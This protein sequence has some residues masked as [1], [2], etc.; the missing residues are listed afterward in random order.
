MANDGSDD[1]DDQARYDIYRIV[2]DKATKG[3]L[4][5]V[6]WDVIATQEV[7]STPWEEFPS[8]GQLRLYVGPREAGC[9][10]ALDWAQPI[11]A[12]RRGKNG[13]DGE[14]GAIRVDGVLITH[15]PAVNVHLRLVPFGP[16]P[17]LKF[18]PGQA[19]DGWPNGIGL[20][21]AWQIVERDHSGHIPRIAIL[22]DSFDD[23]KSLSL[24]PDIE[25]EPIGLPS[26][27]F[28][29]GG[30][31]DDHGIAMTEAVAYVARYAKIG[32][33]S[34][35][36]PD[37][38]YAFPSDVA[39]AVA[40][41]V[42]SWKADIVLLA[43]ANY[44][45]GMP[46][47]LRA[48]LSEAAGAAGRRGRGAIIVAPCGG[49][50]DQIWDRD[51]RMVVAADDFYH[52]PGV[53]SVG[54]VDDDGRWYRDLGVAVNGI[55]P[56]M[57]LCAPGNLVLYGKIGAD[58]ASDASAIIAGVSALVLRRNPALTLAELRQVFRVTATSPATIETPG[59]D[60]AESQAFN[61]RDR[62]QHN[63]KIGF[64]RVAAQA[65]VLAASDPFCYALLA[66]RAFPDVDLDNLTETKPSPGSMLDVALA[67]EEAIAT[68]ELEFAQ[69]YLAVRGRLVR[70]LLVSR[71][72]EDSLFWLARHFRAIHTAGAPDWPDDGRN[73]DVLVHRLRYALATARRDLDRFTDIDGDGKLALWLVE[74]AIALEEVDGTDIARFAKAVGVTPPPALVP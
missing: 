67:L 58:D 39:A 15:E 38:H 16:E 50:Y 43:M 13:V 4:E 45:W 20:I 31:G 61:D 72:L 55:G 51:D 25:I 66:T 44:R 19:L 59:A 32:Y 41:A 40:V 18:T 48:I 22:D 14:N 34:I 71:A 21:D 28:P 56:S 3:D 1:N 73:H 2:D 12:R 53:L 26:G 68:S 24:P 64:G 42:G 62:T 30:D 49:R 37:D 11:V 35:P 69:H 74:A 70:L 9:D 8:L 47:H 46:R 63:L 17:R 36:N 33:L 65:A 5:F 60:Y 7:P 54:A 57:E 6:G 29:R 10:V 23:L 27:R 52:H